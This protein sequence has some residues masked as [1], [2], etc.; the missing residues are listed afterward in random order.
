MS[1][2][3]PIDLAALTA[4][5]ATPMS[6]AVQRTPLKEQPGRGPRPVLQ[7]VEPVVDTV[8]TENLE[9]LSF[10]VSPEFRRRFRQRAATADLKLNELLFEA[11]DAWEEKHRLE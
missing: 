9:G 5:V 11:L 1:K 2:R 4:E 3:P 7:S 6:E 8:K 10:K